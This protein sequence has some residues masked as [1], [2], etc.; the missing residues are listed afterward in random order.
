VSAARGASLSQLGAALLESIDADQ[1]AAEAENRFATTQPT[2][3]NLSA[4]EEDRIKEALKPFHS[5]QLREAIITARRSLEQVIDDQTPDELIRA[6]FDEQAANKSREI[7]KSFREFI[8][9]NREE[10]EAIRILYSRPYRHHL[11]YRHVKDLAAKLGKPPFYID[12]A[13]PESV[14]RLW[15][16]FE[17]AEA[18]SVTGKGGTKLVDLVS[19]VRHAIDPHSPIAPMGMTVDQRY[20]EW[21][22]EKARQ[23][24]TFSKDQQRWL[25]AIKDHIASSLAIEQDDL[26]EVPF[27]TIGGLGRA[28]ELFGDRLNP[29]LE[30]LNSRLAA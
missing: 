24:I 1:I 23:Q 10:I 26:E 2:E 8:E 27:N 13:H 4:V 18:G 9:E 20:R 7:V 11:R 30:E 6:G 25:D 16:A 14:G 22:D 21:L 5:P 3:A 15:Q 19:L 12:P 17:I 28:H 29:L